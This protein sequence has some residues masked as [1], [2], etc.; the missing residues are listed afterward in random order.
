MTAKQRESMIRFHERMA[1]AFDSVGKSDDA[2]EARR[3]AA[4]LREA[5]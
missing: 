4:E 1:K 5:V 3:M 2:A